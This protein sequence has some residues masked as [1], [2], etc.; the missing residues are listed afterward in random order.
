MQ[1]VW[2][3]RF[4]MIA[5]R[6]NPELIGAVAGGQPLPAST[7][8]VTNNGWNMTGDG[9]RQTTA[10][11]SLPPPS[12]GAKQLDQM[13]LKWSLIAVGDMVSLDCDNPTAGRTA[14]QDDVDLRVETFE[15]QRDGRYEMTLSINRE[16]TMPEPPDL[17]FQEYR[18]EMFDDKG[19]AFSPQ[20]RSNLLTEGGVR[21]Q[22]TFSGPSL[23]SHP[24]I[25]RLTYPRLRSQ[26]DVKFT[27]HD[28]P[29]PT[30]RPE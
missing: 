19:Q 5:Y 10:K 9:L 17:V 3:E 12:T 7:T 6:N 29:L 21:C 22:I 11:I 13:T 30:G 18:I 8:P 27:F 4:G 14:H 26:R 23:D 24:K 28:V 16:M 2:E 25:L 1:L 20:Q 15:P